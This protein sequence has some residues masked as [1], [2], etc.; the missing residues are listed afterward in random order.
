MTLSSHQPSSQHL[1]TSPLL[2][3]A[4]WSL[5]SSSL[6]NLILALRF[7]A[8]GMPEKQSP[9]S[10]SSWSEMM[11]VSCALMAQSPKNCFAQYFTVPT[12]YFQVATPFLSIFLRTISAVEVNFNEANYTVAENGGQ[13]SIS[14]RING[15][16]YVPVW[17]IVDINDGTATGGLCQYV[18]Y[19]RLCI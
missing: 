10:P 6:Q 13:A 2:M 8:T 4:C 12:L 7:Q 5:M 19:K 3:I 16:F 15:Q 11:T 1:R 9:S 17:V 14:L 18:C